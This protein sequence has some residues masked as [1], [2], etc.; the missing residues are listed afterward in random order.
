MSRTKITTNSAQDAGH[1]YEVNANH[2]VVTLDRHQ[3]VVAAK[4]AQIT[5][6]NRNHSGN[7]TL[8][9]MGRG[10][11]AGF[12]QCAGCGQTFTLEQLS[13]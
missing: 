3:R 5:K 8:H 1:S 2:E 10:R 12:R 11:L 4:T 7:K 6:C 13:R 9:K